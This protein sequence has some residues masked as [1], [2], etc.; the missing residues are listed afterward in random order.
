MLSVGIRCD[1]ADAIREGEQDMVE[2]SFQ[3][4]AFSRLTAWR[5]T[6]TTPCA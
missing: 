5:N 6:V 2:S 4:R 3:G 1:R